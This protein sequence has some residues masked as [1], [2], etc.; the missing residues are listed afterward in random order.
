ME[1]FYNDIWIRNF[2][3]VFLLTLTHWI[4]DLL[5]LILNHYSYFNSDLSGLKRPIRY[6]I[7]VLSIYK[8]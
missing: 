4:E 2:A 1:G 6:M 7:S 5:W 3:N 8:L